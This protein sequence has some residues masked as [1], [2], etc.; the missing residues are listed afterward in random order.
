MTN[1][2]EGAVSSISG[3]DQLVS[4]TSSGQSV[5]TPTFK[6][7]KDID[8]AFNE[9]QAKVSQVLGLLV[10]TSYSIHYT[11]LYDRMLKSHR[12]PCNKQGCWI[13]SKN[14]E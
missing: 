9:V 7:D 6:L 14:K 10:I 5:V 4:T 2:I 8:V 11:K 1:V 13:S 3:I 12:S